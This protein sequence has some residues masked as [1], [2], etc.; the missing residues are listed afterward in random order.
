MF[1]LCQ[2]SGGPS[3][4]LNDEILDNFQNQELLAEFRLLGLQELIETKQIGDRL[5]NSPPSKRRKIQYNAS[6]PLEDII[7]DIYTAIGLEAG[8]GLDGLSR[9]IK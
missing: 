8:P 7:C 3:I 6:G 1:L 9:V 4:T 5:D 2:A